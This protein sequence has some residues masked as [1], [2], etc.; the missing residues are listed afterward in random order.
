LLHIY[1]KYSTCLR[2]IQPIDLPFNNSEEYKNYKADSLKDFELKE[3]DSN[4][5]E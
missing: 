2:L 4:K 3:I 5:S 1:E